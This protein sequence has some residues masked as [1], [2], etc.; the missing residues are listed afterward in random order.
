M[1]AE[2]AKLLVEY[3]ANLWEGELPATTKVLRNVPDVRRD[4]RPDERSRTA[5][6]LATHLALGDVWFIQSIIE[7]NFNFDPELE[8]KQ[9]ARFQSSKDV[10]EFYEREVPAKLKEL[11]ALPADRLTKVVDFFGM[12]QQPNVT[13]L[14]FANNHSIHHRG[15]LSS[16]LRACGSKV[17]A[18][19]GA[20]ADEPMPAPT[21]S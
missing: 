21:A 17:P 3:F 20:S 15:Q 2:Q 6:E 13:Y 14:G 10:A 18:I 9:A 5:W 7:G 11:R 1:N 4:Y 16:Y 19:Y 8:K 12:M